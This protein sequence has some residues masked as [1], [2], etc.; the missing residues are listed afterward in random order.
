[1]TLA[2]LLDE[3]CQRQPEAAVL[4]LAGDSLSYRHLREQ[5]EALAD[6]LHSQGL[7]SGDT[8]AAVSASTQLIT[9]LSIAC[10]RLG[11]TLFPLSPRLPEVHRD[12][13]LRQAGVSFKLQGEIGRSVEDP[14]I[15]AMAILPVDLKT[16]H[17]R[18]GVKPA[19]IVATSGSSGSPKGVMLSEQALLANA[20]AVNRRLDFQGD[21]CWLHC[22]SSSHIGGLAILYRTLVAG[23][24]MVVVEDFAGERVWQQINQGPVTHISLVPAML[25]ELLTVTQQAPPAGM[26]V[27]L[28]GG[29]PLPAGMAMRARRAGWPLWASYA[30]SEMASQLAAGPVADIDVPAGGDGFVLP[31]LDGV[32][33]EAIDDS[34]MSVGGP[35]RLRVRGEGLMLGYANPEREPGLGLDRQGWFVTGDLGE[36]EAG[37]LRVN[38]RA[39]EVLISGGEK[40][41]PARVEELLR[42]CEGVRQVCVIGTPDPVWGDRVCAVYQGDLTEEVLDAW[43]RSHLAGISRP[44]RFVRVQSFPMLPNGK[45]DRQA[46][47]RMLT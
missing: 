16:V 20:G 34:G 44:R 22:L 8:L 10:S 9:L 35:G 24:T 38:A 13:L 15:T 6:Y 26:R 45:I 25:H 2:A 36:V 41:H 47:K 42:S 37:R 23:G 4:Q 19:L 33:C 18:P 31:L 29:A 43:C 39:D 32:E 7:R 21:D 5:T 40:V 27:A 14:G 1:M 46:I 28:V 11:V 30:M 17:G 12:Q 3:A